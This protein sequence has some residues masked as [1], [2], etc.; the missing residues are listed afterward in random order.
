MKDSSF[1]KFKK[2]LTKKL[3]SDS[4]MSVFVVIL[5]FLFATLLILFSGRNPV[6]L[7]K[8]ILQAVTGLYQDRT[9]NWA[10]NIRYVGNWLTFSLPY[11]LCGFSM[12]FAYRSGLF[13][14]GGEGQ[15]IAGLTAAQVFAFF[16]PQVPVLHWLIIILAALLAGALW[17]GIVGFLKA[18]FEVSEVV[19]TIMLNYIAL[20]VSRIISMGL[21]GANSQRTQEYPV[22]ATLKVDFLEFLTN[23]SPLNLGLFLTLIA[24]IAY[25]F[26][27]EKTN[28]GFSIRATGFNKEAARA[29]GINV[30]SSIVSAMAISGAFAG[31]AGGIIAIGSFRYGR[32][33][34]AMDGYG[35]AGIAVALIGNNNAAGIGFAG[36]LFGMLTEAQGAMQ[37]KG[38]PREITFIIQGVIV[39]FIA[40]R[41]GFRL[42]IGHALN[43]SPKHSPNEKSQQK[44]DAKSDSAGVAK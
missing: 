20:Y 3:S 1:E 30:T 34:S 8:S 24:I 31:L 29:S 43:P 41:T 12:A 13:N 17:G 21:P 19:A 7:Y 28:L 33:I 25:W 38:I 23:G 14:I 22:T 42:W 27:I 40:L 16:A 37:T 35:F 32:V 15:F 39:V 11:I 26:L 4:V 9:G 2:T 5:G 44:A 18:R 10:W 36:L 6:N